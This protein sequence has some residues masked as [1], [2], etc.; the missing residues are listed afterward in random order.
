MTS[1]PVFHPEGTS[2]IRGGIN[3]DLVGILDN[4]C[5]ALRSLVPANVDVL[6]FFTG[7]TVIIIGN[8]VERFLGKPC[9]ISV[10]EAILIIATCEAPFAGSLH[11]KLHFGFR[12]TIVTPQMVEW[13]V[14]R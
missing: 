14:N 12:E 5:C 2:T 1:G 8:W 6:G 11:D 3:V 4:C 10:T 7:D 13:Q 9:V